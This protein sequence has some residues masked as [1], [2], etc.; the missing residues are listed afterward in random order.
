MIINLNTIADDNAHAELVRKGYKKYYFIG[1]NRPHRNLLGSP[2]AE[3][4]QNLLQYRAWLWSQII[5]SNTA[6]LSALR[7]VAL[8]HAVVHEETLEIAALIQRAAKWYKEKVLMPQIVC[9]VCL[10]YLT[11]HNKGDFHMCKECA[12]GGHDDDEDHPED[13][14]FFCSDCSCI[15]TRWISQMYGQCQECRDKEEQ[16]IQA[17]YSHL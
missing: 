14:S 11:D 2:L 5:A 3:G 16:E 7:K 6:I 4:P 8:S 15:L 12:W 17:M 13:L 1:P 9:T 10:T